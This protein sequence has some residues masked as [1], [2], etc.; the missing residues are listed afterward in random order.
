MPTRLLATKLHVP[1]PRSQLVPRPRLLDRLGPLRTLTLVSAPAGFGKTTLLA[2]WI[3]RNGQCEPDLR[4]AWLSLDD[5][6]NDVSR[7]LAYVVAALQTLDADLGSEALSLLADVPA[8]PV[9]AALTALIND[10]ATARG[11]VVLV[12]DDYHVIDAGPVHQAV[13][14]LLDHLP[15][16]L[17]LAIASRSDPPLPLARLRSRGE[18]TE[19]RAADLRFTR[20]EAVD[21][22]NR[23]MDLG[24]S[25]DDIEALETRTEGWIAGL[26]LAALSLRQHQDV[27]G[28]ISTF[29]G[30]HRFVIDYLVEEVLQHQPDDVREFLLRTA[31][32]DRLT[33]PLCDTVTGLDGGSAMLASLD[34]DNLFV[35]ALD[36]Q[37]QWYRYHHLFADVLRSRVLQEH[38]DRVPALHAAASEWYERNGFAEDAA[39]HAVAAGDSDRAAGLMESALPE[40]RRSRHD[41]M[42]LAWLT[43]LPDELVRRRPV[44]SVVRAWL[45]LVAGDLDAVEPWLD[46][47]E[48]GLGTALPTDHPTGA[49]APYSPVEG[50][51]LHLLPVTIAIYRSSLAQAR[52]DIPGTAEH[53]RHALELTEPGDHLERG[54]AA[55]LLGLASWASGDL[56][57]AVQTFSVAVT[58]LRAAGNLADELSSTLVFADMQIARGRLREARRL[59]ER[60]LDLATA[61]GRPRATADLHVGLS[62][63]LREQGDLDAATEHLQ[64]S[65]ALG[66]HTSLTENRYRWFVAMARI[67]EAE[68]DLDGAL[69][70]LDEAERRYVRGFF[71]IVR[72]IPAMKAR[73]RIGQRRLPEA[74]EWSRERG[75]S[76]ADDLSYLHEFEHLTLARLL[77]AE[78]RLPGGQAALRD[79]VGLLERLLAAAEASGRTGSVNE[80]LVLQALADAAQGHRAPALAALDR[81]LTQTRPEGHVR[82]FLDEG[83]PMVALL[84]AAAQQGIAP[85]H[86]GRLLRA[87]EGDRAT[88]VTRHLTE[89]LTK[90]ELQVLGLLQTDLSGPEIAR[91]L[92]LSLNTLR[93]HNKHIFGKLG[94]GSRPAAV[95]RAEQ[96]GLL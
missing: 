92:F 91:E 88:A 30:S 94:V 59:H 11:R 29:T 74:V 22:L 45:L 17:H 71:P 13:G 68:G 14:F 2:E 26:Q 44:L 23:A 49:P 8:L 20:E 76:A 89:P 95:R 60:A 18:L 56:E 27:A 35:S 43:S 75:L 79:A 61:H 10:A 3:A 19:L 63:V 50:A 47:A 73:I 70:L 85:E 6:D 67:R 81:A 4:V 21:F 64:T 36:D 54:A 57:T 28:F 7:F 32:L 62:E 15:P 90:R 69:E 40:A 5:G 16:Q 37:R 12:L 46:E 66:E 83:A 84:R 38:L 1:A 72:P 33:G 41:A 52:G 48:R 80:I 87:S 42:L 93:T 51:D 39:R 78:H 31:F 65:R 34:R 86:V 53:A 24:L 82:L 9:D 55:G 96:L 77:L 58:G 25:A